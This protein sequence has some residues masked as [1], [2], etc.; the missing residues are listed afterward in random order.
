VTDSDKPGAVAIAQTP[1]RPRL[2]DRRHA[3]H[4]GGD[5]ADGH[6]AERLNKVGE[7]SPHVVD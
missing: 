4:G 1:A 6:P 5:R 7:G 3:R 2:P